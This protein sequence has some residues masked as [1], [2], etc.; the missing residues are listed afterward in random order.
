LSNKFITTK[1][2]HLTALPPIQSFVSQKDMIS[3][4]TIMFLFF[5]QNSEISLLHWKELFA[6]LSAFCIFMVGFL[7]VVKGIYRSAS[8]ANKS[9]SEFLDLIPELKRVTA[10]FKPNGG[11]SLKDVMNRM[12]NSLNHTEQK[13]RLITSCLGM[14][15]FE[16]DNE[17][18]YT[19]VSKKWIDVTGFT[20]D[21]AIGNGWIGTVQKEIRKEIKEE[22][23]SCIDQK[24]EF[25]F[26]AILNTETYKSVSIVAWPIKNIDG[27]I[28]KFF[29]ILLL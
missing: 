9:I 17:G 27:S 21:Q 22:W 8:S 18:E 25:H 4:I 19:F 6:A 5:S 13:I 10:E 15:Y 11:K 3:V 12:E 23:E 2:N 29:G 28:E 20:L 16:A 24:R 1:K 14:A 26:N 7:K